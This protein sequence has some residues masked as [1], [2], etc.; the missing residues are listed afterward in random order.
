MTTPTTNLTFSSIQTEVTIDDATE[1]EIWT[2]A[3]GS[4]QL[5]PSELQAAA[6]TAA[7]KRFIPRT[8]L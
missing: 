6:E 8:I 1:N 4:P 7:K 3:D 2:T 5:S